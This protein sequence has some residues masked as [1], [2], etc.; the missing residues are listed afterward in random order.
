[1]Q[2][3]SKPQSPRTNEQRAVNV[4]HQIRQAERKLSFSERCNRAI[5]TWRTQ[6]QE[7]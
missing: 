6:Q 1:M 4:Q 2:S 7:S 5:N 3:T